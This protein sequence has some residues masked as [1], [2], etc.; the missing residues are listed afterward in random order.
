ML[1]CAPVFLIETPNGD[2]VGPKLVL[3]GSSQFSPK[4]P[5]DALI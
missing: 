2:S 3:S 1:S 5:Y 4:I